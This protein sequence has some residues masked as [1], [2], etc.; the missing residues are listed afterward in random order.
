MWLAL[1]LNF[2]SD[3][4]KPESY[5]VM[6]QRVQTEWITIWICCLIVKTKREAGSPDCDDVQEPSEEPSSEPSNETGDSNDTVDTA[7]TIDTA[8]PPLTVNPVQES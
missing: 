6:I 7:D 4:D 2:C 5:E 3:N 8:N 1:L